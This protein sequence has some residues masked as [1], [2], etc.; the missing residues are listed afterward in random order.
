MKISAEDH[1]MRSFLG[2]QLIIC[3]FVILTLDKAFA[4]DRS[5]EVNSLK[6]LAD[7]KVVVEGV[8]LEAE[9]AGLK[10]VDLQSAIEKGIKAAGLRVLSANE[11]ARGTPVVYLSAVV[12]PASKQD[13]ELF[14]Y[15][16]EL[17]VTQ[18]TRLSRLPAVRVQSPTWR[19]PGAIGT[20]AKAELPKLKATVEGY[21]KRLADDFRAANK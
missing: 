13:D 2:Q 9:A 7:V 21:A 3:C 6:G 8:S 19:P 16:I 15:S 14:V 4:A 11:R 5:A 20:T 17:S 10:K 1:A 12:F 18:E